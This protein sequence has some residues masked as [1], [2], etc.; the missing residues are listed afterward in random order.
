MQV[1]LWKTTKCAFISLKKAYQFHIF[2]P[3]M[4]INP[5]NSLLLVVMPVSS[6]HLSSVHVILPSVQEHV[7]QSCRHVAP[8]SVHVELTARTNFLGTPYCWPWGQGL[9]EQ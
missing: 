5:N 2:D 9:R 3:I 7:L 8:S 6:S 4:K 1:T